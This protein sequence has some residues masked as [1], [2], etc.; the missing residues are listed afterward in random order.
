MELVAG[1]D[2]ILMDSDSGVVTAGGRGMGGSGRGYGE[3]NDR[4]K[5]TIR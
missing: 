5:N 4:G 2:G 3:I 1:R